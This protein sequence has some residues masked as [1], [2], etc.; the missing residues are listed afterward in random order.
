MK[1]LAVVT[2]PYIYHGCS[3]R[4]TFWEEKFTGKKSF[5]LDVN[6]K[7]CGHHNVRKH[8]DIKGSDKYVSLDISSKFDILDKIKITSSES[9]GKLERSV[10]GFITSLCFKA[11]V[12]P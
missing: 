9:K 7:N 5:F 11:K 2:P 10:K 4:K 3:T 8:K 12:R 1:L 6:M